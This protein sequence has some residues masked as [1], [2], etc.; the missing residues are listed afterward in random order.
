MAKR[1]RKATISLGLT[2]GLILGGI[3]LAK[4]FG[5]GGRIIEGF[6]GLGSTIG[7][8]PSDVDVDW[9]KAGQA[10]LRKVVD[11]AAD[12]MKNYPKDDFANHQLL[13]L[14]NTVGTGAYTKT[15]G[16]VAQHIAPILGNGAAKDYATNVPLL[17][18]SLS[19]YTRSQFSGA[20]PRIRSEF[21]TVTSGL[22]KNTSPQDQIK[23]DA[24]LNIA[25]RNYDNEANKFY[26]SN[27]DNA[28]NR[29]TEGM[30]MAFDQNQGGRSILSYAMPDLQKTTIN[31]KPAVSNVVEYQGHHWAQF[32]PGSS[33]PIKFMI[34]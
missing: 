16:D 2:A 12:N 29:T 8:A 22:P 3:F 6:G 13:S 15:L 10:S 21:D 26:T 18:Q 25:K 19:N 11:S 5:V 30:Q 9:E 24:L 17:A 20:L 33:H 23:I 31:G 27:A 28:K 7:E 34:D 14:A 32:L 4:R 1:V